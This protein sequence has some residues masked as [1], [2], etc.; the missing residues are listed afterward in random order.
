EIHHL[1]MLMNEVF[2]EENFIAS[3][4]WQ[5]AYTS[6]MTAKHLS[7]THDYIVVYAKEPEQTHVARLDRT[8]GQL[9]KFTNT[10]GDPRGP[11]KAENLSAGKFYAAGQFEIVTPSG[12]KVAP[13]EGRFWRCN[14]EQYEAWVADNRISFGKDGN[15]RP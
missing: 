4:V 15:G 6:N 1:R 10:D 2:G 7:D 11:W 5:K 8:E 9:A 12:R 13:P 14:Q 3:C